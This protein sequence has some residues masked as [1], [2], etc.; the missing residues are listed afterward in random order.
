MKRFSLK[1]AATLAATGIVM[2]GITAGAQA[3]SPDDDVTSGGL[4]SRTAVLT[5]VAD[6]GAD[7][8][9][10]VVHCA[11]DASAHPHHEAVCDQLETSDGHVN[12]VPMID[13][14]CTMEHDPVE[15]HA[16]VIWDGEYHQFQQEFGN[17]CQANVETGGVIFDF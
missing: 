3:E 13:A 9:N 5:I 11:A 14:Y 15:L 2:A 1:V 6:E 10:E 17:P 12:M 16:W 8:R 4:F 7:I